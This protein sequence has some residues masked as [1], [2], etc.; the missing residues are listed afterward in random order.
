MRAPGRYTPVIRSSPMGRL[1]PPRS[2]GWTCH[3][4]HLEW[5]KTAR[6]RRQTMVYF[7]VGSVLVAPVVI[8]F[9]PR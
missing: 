9:G 8:G 3:V 6:A 4:G 5:A 2:S 7:S 1:G